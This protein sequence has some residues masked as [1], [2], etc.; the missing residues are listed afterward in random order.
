MELGAT[1]SPCYLDEVSHQ[2]PPEADSLGGAGSDDILD[3]RP[4]LAP[5][6]EVGHDEE[7]CRPYDLGIEVR[8]RHSHPGSARICASSGCEAERLAGAVVTLPPASSSYSD[9]TTPRFAVPSVPKA[10]SRVGRRLPDMP[11][12]G[13]AAVEP[14]A[15]SAHVRGSLA[16]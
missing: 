15:S 1:S 6:G 11:A 14:A 13:V 8:E 16:L 12:L 5:M 3:Y 9:N 7:I 10:L 4:R 2:R